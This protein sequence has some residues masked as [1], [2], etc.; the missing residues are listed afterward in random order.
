[1]KT[2]CVEHND[3]KLCIE[4]QHFHKMWEKGKTNIGAER[5]TSTYSWSDGVN[6]V[7]LTDEDESDA[8]RELSAGVPQE[9]AFFF[10]LTDYA[11]WVEFDKDVSSA[12]VDSQRA[13]V[14]ERFSWRAPQ[15][16]LMGFLNYGN[17][18]GRAD[19]PLRYKKNG[20]WHRFVFSYDVISAKLD[21]H[22]D[23]Q[24]ILHDIEQEY[25]M[26]SLDYL[27]RTYHGISTGD[28]EQYDLIWW[29]IFGS[30]QQKF[31]ASARNIVERPRHRLRAVPAYKRADQIRRFTTTLEQQFAEHRSEESRLYLVDE[32]Q[33]T[34]NT[35]EN[36]FLKYALNTISKHYSDLARRIGQLKLPIAQAEL[37]RIDATESQ[38]K[39]LVRHPFF[40][41]VGTFEGLRQESLI[42]Q[43]DTNYSAVYR[44]YLI[45]RKSFSLNDGLYRMETKDIATLY[46]IW[47]FIEVS[48]IVQE[49]LGIEKSD[50]DHRNRMEMSS[51]FT[52]ELGKGERS[53][54]VFKK[55]GVEL[56]ELVYNPKHSETDNEDISISGIASRTV[57][58]KPDIVLRL[59]KNDVERGMKMTYLFD[60]KYRIGDKDKDENKADVPP[61]D[62]INQMHRYR[63]AIYYKE[64]DDSA[65]KKEVIG[66]Y[67]L[68]P[69][70][71]ETNAVQMSKFYKSIG[72][73]NIGAFPLRPKNDENRKLLGDFIREL[74]GK[75]SKETIEQV[76][77]QKGA[78]V[79]VSTRVLV[80]LVKQNSD[81]FENGTA[82]IYYTR[83]H[84]PTTISLDHLHWFTPYIK[85]KGVRDV[86][87][88]TRIRT[89]TSA[90]AKNDEAAGNDLRLAFE[91]GICRR[92]SD[93]YKPCELNVL[94]TFRDTTIGELEN[95]L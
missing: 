56:A 66:G 90:E 26:L 18:I 81:K 70:N 72:D 71:G 5:L 80:G 63:D 32:Q 4:C 82:T 28:G 9:P 16:I 95:D 15:H 29:N 2:L 67:I 64:Y 10:E 36:R 14:N 75:K 79:E 23:W 78:T 89:I 21:Y 49:Q 84:F 41:T 65:L 20:E 8:V 68:F 13:D 76:I 24:L 12:C 27:R 3:F 19:F 58:Q 17:D 69:G 62:A 37:D 11:V 87:E 7:V 57:P 22:H 53:H 25:R 83:S 94:E 61:D 85:G 33:H 88:I 42:L 91:L 44:T 73:V 39:S 48:H 31:I 52:W 46:E 34:H 35:I 47:C 45:L 60:A 93:D 1:M 59:T 43:R 86:Y 6:S 54:I 77:P 92:L 51:F 38:L 30:L 74:I 50:I 40:R 55:D